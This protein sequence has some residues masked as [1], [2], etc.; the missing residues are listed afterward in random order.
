MRIACAWHFDGIDLDTWSSPMGIPRELKALGHEVSY[1]GYDPT[2]SGSSHRKGLPGE[3]DLSHIRAVADSFDIIMFFMSGPSAKFDEELKL[4]KKSTTAKIYMEFGDDIPPHITGASYFGTRKHFVDGIFT[5]DKRCDAIYK[6]EGLPSHWMP[7]WC[8]ELIFHKTDTVRQNICV[9]TCIGDRPLLNDFSRH[10]GDKF[11]HKQVWQKDNTE[12]YNS[13]TFT[14]QFARWD[15]LTRRIFEAGGCGNAVLTN[16]IS[17]DTGIYDLFEED[18]DLAY[19]SSVEEAYA[20][21][22]RLYA[23]EEYRTKL[24]NNLYNK[25]INNHLP[26]HRVGQ[27]LNVYNTSIA[28]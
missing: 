1:F 14:Y 5:L 7:C 17:A 10:Y 23:D 13:G 24:A 28:G 19:F 20:K 26:K 9:T 6:S 2:P 8:D 11:V 4:L 18:V 22:D 15:E 21:M 3:C 27:I 25:V 16:R 12:F